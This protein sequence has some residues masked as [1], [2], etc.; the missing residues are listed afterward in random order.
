MIPRGRI[1]PCS[2]GGSLSLPVALS[3]PSLPYVGTE[4]QGVT[5]RRM[6]TERHGV[7]Q[8]TSVRMAWHATHPLSWGVAFRPCAHLFR[9]VCSP[10]SHF[11]CWGSAARGTHSRA[12]RSRAAI[13]SQ[14]PFWLK[15]ACL[16]QAI[17]AQTTEALRVMRKGRAPLIANPHRGKDKSWTA[18]QHSC[19]GLRLPSR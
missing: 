6:D 19:D 15:A 11:R 7:R 9:G 8:A 2:Q 10:P 14:T 18:P 17:T 13:L 1:S 16:V 12:R 5:A 3:S 4:R